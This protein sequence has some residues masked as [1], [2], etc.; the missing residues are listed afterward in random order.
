MSKLVPNIMKDINTV[1]NKVLSDSMVV[2]CSIKYLVIDC[3]LIPISD[4]AQPHLLH[5]TLLSNN[6][7]SFTK[8]LIPNN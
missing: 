7:I 3:S 6:A 8:M 2:T 1:R 5:G 4:I